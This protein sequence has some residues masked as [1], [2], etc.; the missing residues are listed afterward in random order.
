MTSATEV[1]TNSL[2]SRWLA[3]FTLCHH[4]SRVVNQ[5]QLRNVEHFLP[6]YEKIS[7][8]RDRRVT[9]KQPLFP[10]YVF[11]RVSGLQKNDVLGSPGVVS[12]VGPPGRPVEIKPEEIWMLQTAVNNFTVKPTGYI[13]V[14]DRVRIHAGV[15]GGFSGVVCREANKCRVV[16]SIDAI[17]RS[18]L[19]EVDTE[20]VGKG[21]Q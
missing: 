17:Q 1:A 20:L 9:L 8:W 10:G 11:V 2:H 19:V 4:E 16:I 18:F 6:T 5:L 12:L 14:G 21:L 7:Q 3:A 13:K 15:F